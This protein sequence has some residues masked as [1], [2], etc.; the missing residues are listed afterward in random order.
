MRLLIPQGMP[1]LL[2][3]SFTRMDCSPFRKYESGRWTWAGSHM[4]CLSGQF[5]PKVGV[6]LQVAV[7]PGG[8]LD[9]VMQGRAEPVNAPVLNGLI[10]TG[11][12]QTCISPN[13]ANTLELKP[14]G[15]IPVSGATGIAEMNQYLIDLMLQFGPNSISI[16]NHTVTVFTSHSSNYEMLIGRDIICRGIFTMEF[17]GHF[18]FSI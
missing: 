18:S 16:K 2:V 11:A 4:P 12:D 3:K 9:K 14:T 7:L 10:D 15:K 6:L 1:T 13:V 5:D 17:S 8:T